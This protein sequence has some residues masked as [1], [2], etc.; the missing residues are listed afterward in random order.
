MQLRQKQQ[1]K[2]NCHFPQR[3]WCFRLNAS[4]AKEKKMM[5]QLSESKPGPWTSYFLGFLQYGRL[6]F[7]ISWTR[8]DAASTSVEKNNMGRFII[9]SR[10]AGFFGRFLLFY[11]EDDLHNSKNHRLI[12]LNILIV[13]RRISTSSFPSN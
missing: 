1:Q 13:R 7:E 5:I 8:V 6:I 10:V 12:I 11:I 2:K 9:L 3:L 4:G